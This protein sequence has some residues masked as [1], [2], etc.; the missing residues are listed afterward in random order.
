MAGRHWWRLR[1]KPHRATSDVLA[2]AYPFLAEEGLGS[3]GSLIGVDYWSGTAFVYDPFTLYERKV[4]TNPNMLLAGALGR[5]KCMLAK[6]LACRQIAFGRRIYIPGDVKGEWSVVAEA[7]G[8]AVIRLGVGSPNRLNPLD[9]GPRPSDAG[10]D[11]WRAQVTKRR[12]SLLAALAE[13]AVGRKLGPEERNALAV[14][15]DEAVRVDASRCCR[16]WWTPCTTRGRRWPAPR[17]P[18]CGR[19][20]VR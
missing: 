16:W 12:R 15:L 14:A 13:V 11:E 17:S 5:G 8:G 19:T 3:V 18:N 10:D 9:E 20:A 6:S 4:L 7:V 2:V 1:V